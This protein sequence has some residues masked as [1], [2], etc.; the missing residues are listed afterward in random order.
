MKKLISFILCLS[1]LITIFPVYGEDIDS[2]LVLGCLEC[3]LAE[4]HLDN[5]SQFINE[6]TCGEE[7]HIEGCNLFIET[8]DEIFEENSE[9][10]D[11]EIEETDEILEDFE[12]VD[13]EKIDKNIETIECTC[14]LEEHSNDCPLYE[15]PNLSYDLLMG[16][17]NFID[18]VILFENENYTDFIENLSNEERENLISQIELLYSEL[19][20]PTEEEIE[21]KLRLINLLNSYIVVV[22]E[23]CGEEEGHSE[24]CSFSEK[25]S[26]D[27]EIEGIDNNSELEDTENNSDLVYSVSPDTEIIISDFETLMGINNLDELYQLLLE[28]MFEKGEDFLTENEVQALYDKVVE[29]NEIEE[30]EYYEDL[31]DTLQYI[32][33]DYELN[34]AVILADW[35]GQTSGTYTVPSS[36]YTITKEI[37][38]T[39]TLTLNGS[40]MIN[41]G[42]SYTG[43][44]FNIKDGGKLVINGTT[45]AITIN[46]NNKSGITI[47]CSEN[48]ELTNVII[49]NVQNAASKSAGI[50]VTAT[51]TSSSVIKV[52]NC[53]FINCN[54][55]AGAALYLAGA[56]GAKVTVSNTIIDDC[57]TVTGSDYGGAIRTNGA[58]K[59]QFVLRDSV[60]RNCDSQVFGGGVYWNAVG[61]GA[62]ITIEDCHILN[63]TAVERGGGIFF[64]GSNNE[65]IANSGNPTSALIS[66]NIPSEGIVGTLIQG[67]KAVDGAGICY[68]CYSNTNGIKIP[69]TYVSFGENVV[70]SG[71]SATNGAGVAF[72]LDASDNNYEIGSEFTF[73]IDGAIIEDNT[74]T[75]S[76][77]G[78]F[79]RK[80]RED[81]IVN[82]YMRS[83]VVENNIAANG[84]GLGMTTLDGVLTGGN[85]TMIGGTFINNISTQNG[86]ALYIQGGNIEIFDGVLSNNNAEN[87]GGAIY[88][89]TDTVNVN[90]SVYDG[91]IIGNESGNHAGAIGVN[92]SSGCSVTLN[93]GELFCKGEN[94][95]EHN[96]NTCP[97]ISDNIATKFGG[98]FCL[99]GDAD[100]LF[101]NFYCGDIIGNKAIRNYGSNSLKQNGGTVTVYGG[102]ID[103]G[104]MVGGGS[105]TDT[106]IDAEQVYFNLWSNYPNGPTEPTVIDVTRGVTFVFPSDTYDWSG[107]I[108]SGWASQPDTKGLYV[109]VQGEY[110]VDEET[111]EYSDFYA[112]WDAQTSYIVYIPEKIIVNNETGEGL[113]E[114]S[115]DVNYFKK[116]S[117]LNVYIESDL[118]LEGINTGTLCDFSIISD[119]NNEGIQS[120]DILAWYKYNYRDSKLVYL[121]L[122]DLPKTVDKYSGYLTFTIEYSEVEDE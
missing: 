74:A 109:P 118:V 64:E 100:K 43:I 28:M 11:S 9:N 34:N 16:L 17:E 36:G 70:I 85:Y 2:D 110:V 49:K 103:P 7:V 25:D 101:V 19:L 53:Q 78:I 56:G 62:K 83:G 69:T 63:N 113:F 81:Y 93:I 107:H 79:V 84:G 61:A 82:V 122:D 117:L 1:M 31:V 90:I 99:H 91:E 86:G 30:Y 29:M 76:G 72:M 47:N 96:D 52:T 120:G 38:I 73:N 22:C 21:L 35:S 102:D 58:G 88:V 24:D 44:L 108:L 13:I 71:N 67:N 18:W 26:P 115:A 54:S 112:V 111:T 55:Y 20:E 75:N 98:A 32:A 27:L 106:R 105:Y 92:A 60:V 42:S 46:G 8:N 37:T 57:D 14:D 51:T 80:G 89:N 114:I 116:D 33:G 41:R 39:G 10:I 48:L 6:C 68:K 95:T 3:G 65:I 15:K 40:G 121:V 119:E 104:I 77:G 94:I 50:Q 12:N 66:G 5:C 45:G 4:G 87:N 23:E 59:Y 97:V